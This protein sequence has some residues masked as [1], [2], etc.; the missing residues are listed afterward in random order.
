MLHLCSPVFLDLDNSAVNERLKFS[1]LKRLPPVRWSD[2]QMALSGLPLT[3]LR[4][5]GLILHPIVAL[6]SVCPRVW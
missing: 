4:T 1:V 6:A 5:F 3:F 2:V